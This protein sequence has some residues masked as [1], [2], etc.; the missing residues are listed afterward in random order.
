MILHSL[1]CINLNVSG[2]PDVT[3][4]SSV[5]TCQL[6][7]PPLD[8]ALLDTKIYPPICTHSHTQ[9]HNLSF[10]FYCLTDWLKSPPNLQHSQQGD[11][12]P[13]VSSPAPRHGLE[14][15]D[16]RP[17]SIMADMT[18]E[19][20]A[21]TLTPSS[22]ASHDSLMDDK[23]LTHFL[24]PK[25]C[26]HTRIFKHV[27]CIMCHAYRNLFSRSHSPWCSYV[28]VIS[29][30]LAHTHTHRRAHTQTPSHLPNPSFP[31]LISSLLSSKNDSGRYFHSLGRKTS[32]YIEL[33]HKIGFK[34]YCSVK[35]ALTSSYQ[36]WH[37]EC[38][39]RI[40]ILLSSSHSTLGW[41]TLLYIWDALAAF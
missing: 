38:I 39:L 30:I 26:M 4:Q 23:T 29:L 35:T 18:S 12:L 13:L 40:P 27:Q 25:W 8:L 7:P 33:S 24:T 22:H 31:R 20:T 1:L 2:V 36:T 10:G 14:I 37:L 17:G 21:D 32:R 34:L 16:W 28:K 6:T 5:N 11:A 3:F 9:T 15:G 41:L 19:V